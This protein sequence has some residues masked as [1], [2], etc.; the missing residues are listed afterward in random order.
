MKVLAVSS[1]GGHWI[2][3]K[4]LLPAFESADLI[5]IST[6]KKLPLL[7]D[8]CRYYSI[9]D[10]S[11]WNKFKLVQQ[12]FQVFKV[13]LKERPDKIVTTGASIGVWALLAGKLIGGKTIWID[14]I[15][16]SE[17]ISLSGLLVKSFVDYHLTQWP[18]LQSG[19]TIFK[20]SVL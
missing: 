3:L 15:A 17:K 20:G 2:Q 7:P 10:A 6:F 16:N 18:E 5:M 11:R 19:K 14:S 8:K 9:V 12:A 1:Q 13:V 4:R